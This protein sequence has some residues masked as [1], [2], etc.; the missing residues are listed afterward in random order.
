MNKTDLYLD[1]VL[2][3]LCMAATPT[4]LLDVGCG[5][6]SPIQKFSSKIARTVGLDGFAPSIQ[7]SRVKNI[8]SEYLQ[9]DLMES[10]AAL[11]SK[12][13][14]VVIAMDVI[15]HFEKEP[16][17]KFLQE[18]ERVAKKRVIVF[19]PNGF[20]PQGEYDENPNQLHRSGWTTE[21]FVARGYS[22]SGINGLKWL[23]GEYGAPRFKPRWLANRLSDYTQFLTYSY[24][25]MAFQI[26][27]S[28]DL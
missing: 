2:E 28:K 11:K 21:E 19:T 3:K 17:W 9:G 20:L 7:K 24:P 13:F 18:L 14:D 1:A 16:G 10:L 5:A 12:S 15:E 4:S 25:S 22:V 6:N 23:K 8:H 27:A 26:L